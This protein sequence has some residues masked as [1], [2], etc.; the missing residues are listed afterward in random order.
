M[1]ANL[2]KR[3][4]PQGWNTA[5]KYPGNAGT[6][7]TYTPGGRLLTR[8]WARTVGGNALTTTYGYDAAGNRTLV[9]YSDGTPDV[10][11]TYTRFGEMESMSDATGTRSYTYDGLLRPVGENLPAFYGNRILSRGIDSLGRSSGMAV[12]VSGNLEGDY[13]VAYGY[14]AAGRLAGVQDASTT[15]SYGIVAGSGNLVSGVTSGFSNVAYDYESDRD[16][17]S[18]ISNKIGATTLSAYAYSNNLLGQRTVRSQSGS[19]FAST[20][21]DTFSYNGTGELTGAVNDVES[22]RSF[23]YNY[24]GIGNRN[25]ASANTTTTTYA[26]NALNQYEE[27]TEGSTVNPNTVDLRVAG[28]IFPCDAWLCH[29]KNPNDDEHWGPDRRAPEHRRLGPDIS[30]GKDTRHS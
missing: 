18:E 9:D 27:I 4:S 21:A 30:A 14:D 7:Y 10:G 12:G 29:G 6:T 5:H 1:S 28:L 26:A 19:A 16:L 17:V 24:D 11:N 25:T 23:A 2:A 20:S 8:T 3:R 13:V 15:W 22:A